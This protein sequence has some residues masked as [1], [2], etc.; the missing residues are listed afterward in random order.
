MPK[1]VFDSLYSILVRDIIKNYQV[2][3]KY[4]SI[5]ELAKKHKVSTQTV[6]RG[7]EKLQ[8]SGLITVRQKAGIVISSLQPIGAVDNKKISVISAIEDTRFVNSF[9]K[10]MKEEGEKKGIK[11]ILEDTANLDARSLYFGEYICS[12]NTDGI[13]TLCYPDSGLPFYHALKEGVDIV[14]DLIL[15]ELPIL[16]AV[17]TDNYRHSREAGHLFLNQGYKRIL[18]LG[19]YPAE[20]NRRYEG[21]RDIAKGYCDEV[22]YIS[23][24]QVDAIWKIDRFFQKFDSYSAVFSADYSANYIIA[25]K[26]IQYRIPVKNNNFLVYDCEE[27]AFLYSKLDPI[28]KVGPALRT[29]GS[30]L[31]KTLISKWENGVY[32]QPLQR[33]I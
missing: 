12:L 22:Q 8:K 4:P 28:Q 3:D 24:S 17:Q 25:A 32:P 6:Q 33:K 26:F 29:I 27:D 19:Y 2:G 1:K 20:R 30:E 7:I 31:C 13:I 11:I 5:R 18:V 21:L 15:D 16:P 23:L 10:G 9:I 14:S